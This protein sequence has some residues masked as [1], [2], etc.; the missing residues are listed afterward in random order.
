LIMTTSLKPLEFANIVDIGK[1][2]EIKPFKLEESMELLK[3][4]TQNKLIVLMKDDDRMIPVVLNKNFNNLPLAIRILGNF[5]LTFIFKL[6]DIF[7]ELTNLHGDN[8]E[9]FHLISYILD[10]AL[11]T[12]DP[13]T[14]N[15]RKLLEVISFLSPAGIPSQIFLQSDDSLVD[16][17]ERVKDALPN[18]FNGF[19]YAARLECFSEKNFDDSCKILEKL[20]LIEFNDEL[21]FIHPLIQQ[22]VRRIVEE[23]ESACFVL[24]PLSFILQELFVENNYNLNNSQSNENKNNNSNDDDDNNDGNNNALAEEDPKQKLLKDM[25]KVFINVLEFTHHFEGLDSVLLYRAIGQYFS[26]RSQN[27]T[28]AEYYYLEALRNLETVNFVDTKEIALNCTCLSAC[29]S[30]LQ[31]FDKAIHYYTRAYLFWHDNFGCQH[32]NSTTILQQIAKTY[33]QKGDT[34]KALETYGEV[35]K[36]LEDEHG[37]KSAKLLDPLLQIALI[38]HSN[39]QLLDAKKSY[40]RALE[41]ATNEYGQDNAHRGTILFK[42][43]QMSEQLNE[44]GNAEKQ[45][46]EALLIFRNLFPSQNHPSIT[47]CINIMIRARTS[48]KMLQQKIQEL[49]S[50]GTGTHHATGHHGKSAVQK[51]IKMS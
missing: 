42:L 16:L 8:F 27:F 17:E 40:M 15:A 29:Y 50:G 45:A 48:L 41:I 37:K 13:T 11:S 33:S 21:I 14:A 26:M 46:E 44:F 43:A 24:K 5:S 51:A 34:K 3:I 1:V 9:F 32:A 10:T 22:Y 31:N 38:Q 25:N 30:C 18:V 6:A 49:E 19:D 2:M 36:Y 20:G 47:N 28:Q 7:V 35:L 12:Q 39:E 4:L 23:R